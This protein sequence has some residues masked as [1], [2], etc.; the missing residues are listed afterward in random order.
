ML[1]QSQRAVR[2]QHVQRMRCDEVDL[3]DA[4]VWRA[5]QFVTHSSGG[6]RAAVE[7]FST[8][9]RSGGL[10]EE[11]VASAGQGKGYRLIRWCLWEVIERC[12]TSRSC[13]NC[14]LAP[15]CRGRAR[16]AEGFLSIDDAIAIAQRSSRSSW[17]AEMLCRGAKRDWLVF[18]EFDAARHVGAVKYCRDWPLYRAIDFGY[19]DPLVC[20]WVQV[21]PEGVVRV[22]DEYARTQRPIIQHAR[23]I[24]S[25]DQGKV[26]MTYVDPAGRQKESTTGAAC[27]ELLE[28]AGIPCTCRQSSIAEGL[29]LIRAALDPAEGAD[30]DYTPDSMT[31]AQPRAAVPHND[32]TLREPSRGPGILCG[33]DGLPLSPPRPPLPPRLLIDERCRGLIAAF[34]T[35]H[36]PPPGA[37]GQGDKPV[38]DGPDHFIDALR[39]FFV[40]RKRPR[41]GMNKSTY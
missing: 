14:P 6:V 32:A 27:T 11:L 8:L 36:Y 35:Y 40:N 28:A 37:S 4:E 7:V 25:R 22:I 13:A 5:L 15:D 39:Y 21:T 17:E 26:A 41:L 12:P 29:E 38:K 30:E 18:Q 33:P 10:M 19:T 2:G 20:L 23:E 3:F 1:A 31:A 9:H 24:L 34:N 16:E